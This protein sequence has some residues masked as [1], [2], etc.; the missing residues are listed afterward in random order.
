MPHQRPKRRGGTVAGVKERGYSR[1]RQ[2]RLKDA[3]RLPAMSRE[4]WRER[5]R[6]LKAATADDVPWRF[7]VRTSLKPSRR[8]DSV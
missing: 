3:P 2:E 5:F 4:E 1:E 8:R 6:D 7:P